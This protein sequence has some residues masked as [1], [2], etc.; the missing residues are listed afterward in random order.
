MKC[1]AEECKADISLDG[2]GY[3]KVHFQTPTATRP[4]PMSW[5]SYETGKKSG[6]K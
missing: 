4:C 3:I 5:A 6:E 2:K 1:K